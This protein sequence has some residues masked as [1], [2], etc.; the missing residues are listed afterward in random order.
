[1]ISTKVHIC[2]CIS[3]FVFKLRSGRKHANV[4]NIYLVVVIIYR[5]IVCMLFH[6]LAY[7]AYVLMN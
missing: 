2:L 3:R 7:P 1:M 5:V 6:A 4:T